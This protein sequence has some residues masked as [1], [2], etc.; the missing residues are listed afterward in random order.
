MNTNEIAVLREVVSRVARGPTV[1]GLLGWISPAGT[2]VC[3][4]CMSKLVQ[5]G[6]TKALRGSRAVYRQDK[7][8]VEFNCEVHP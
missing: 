4:L 2:R 3:Q 1:D 8:A 6:A 5:V 7:E